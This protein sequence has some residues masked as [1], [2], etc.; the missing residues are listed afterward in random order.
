MNL[1][2][3]G[4]VE[5]IKAL[6]KAVEREHTKTAV[7]EL[8]YKLTTGKPLR[9]DKLNAIIDELHRRCAYAP[10]P[11]RGEFVLALLPDE[12]PS[13]ATRQP[14]DADDACYF[15]AALAAS[16]DIECRFVLARY[17]R[18]SW[19]CFIAYENEEG[20]WQNINPLREK[21]EQVPNELVMIGR[22]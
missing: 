13:A 7:R 19:T 4:L 5:A 12:P 6:N 20:L 1:L 21:T 15:V 8:A 18:A 3:T 22:D 10:D 17:G 2:P 9:R 14:I 16:I 11:I